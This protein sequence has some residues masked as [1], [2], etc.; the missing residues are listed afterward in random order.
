MTPRAKSNYQ[1]KVTDPLD[2]DAA[3]IIS[4]DIRTGILDQNFNNGYFR[5]MVSEIRGAHCIQWKCVILE[6]RIALEIN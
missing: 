3:E 2:E 4:S 6:W 5:A 1:W